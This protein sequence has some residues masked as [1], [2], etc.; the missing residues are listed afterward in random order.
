M[1][2]MSYCRWENTLS[3]LQDCA[4][5]LHDGNLSP[6]EHVSRKRL[7]RL[8]A[9]MLGEIGV[10]VDHDDLDQALEGAP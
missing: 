4:D 1:A 10:T 7:L 8:A 6:T 2:N 9:D 5:H 3:D